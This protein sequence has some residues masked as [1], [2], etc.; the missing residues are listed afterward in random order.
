MQKKRKITRTVFKKDRRRNLEKNYFSLVQISAMRVRL[1]VAVIVNNTV[2]ITVQAN[3][4]AG[5]L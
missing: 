3:T 5:V 2:F 1:A 4:A